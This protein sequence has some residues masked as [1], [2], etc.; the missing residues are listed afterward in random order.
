ML[1]DPPARGHA[2][3][4]A[5]RTGLIVAVALAT[6]LALVPPSDASAGDY[7]TVRERKD[8]LEAQLGEVTAALDELRARIA[9][10]REEIE[11]LEEREAE[12]DAQVAAL[13]DSLADRA[14]SAFKHSGE[15]IPFQSLFDADSPDEA[16][17]RAG[18][19]AALSR[20]D[21][22]ALEQAT[23]LRERQEQVRSLLHARSAELEAMEDD[24]EVRGASLQDTFEEV[25]EEY[26]E[27]RRVRDR[28]RQ[29]SRGA[30]QGTYACIFD[31]PHHFRDT[32]GDARSGGRR[33]QGTD[34]MAP[35]RAP[36]YAIT[37]GVVS[38][39]SRSGLGGIGLY[40][41][42]DDGVQYYY[43][44][45][46]GYASGV[47]VGQR[48]QAGEHIGYNGY[49]GNASPSAPHVHFE[50]HPGGGAAVNPYPWLRA[51][52]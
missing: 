27:L 11:E 2:R 44:H 18:L 5:V 26:T 1:A 46:D 32:W 13:G 30:Q 23:A 35:Y 7:E 21:I 36:V 28:Q 4:R 6:V 47:H 8:A 40:L 38:R 25:S 17:E 19:V 41:R 22:A 20:R 24:L 50:A 3:P 16:V 34:V 42:G 15:T 45:L 9:V 37:N 33:H 48:V 49:T 52:C 10:T 43:A 39:M 51:A 12:L 29:V 31:G 14:R